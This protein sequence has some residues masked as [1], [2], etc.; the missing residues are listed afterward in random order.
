MAA[1]VGLYVQF[2]S[3]PS[4]GSTLK[5]GVA[6]R[7]FGLL[8]SDLLLQMDPSAAGRSAGYIPRR[9]PRITSLRSARPAPEDPRGQ[10]PFLARFLHLPRVPC[11]HNPLSTPTAPCRRPT[12]STPSPAS[13]PSP[14]PC[15]PP[16]SSTSIAS[17][18]PPSWSPTSA[19]C[20]SRRPAAWTATAGP[21]RRAGS[22]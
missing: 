20:P 13:A 8:R 22:S 18:R 10:G 14:P 11:Y 15:S 7:S 21:A 1:P 2:H 12:A 16:S 19:S 9:R 3:R 5:R 6:R 4:F 17:R